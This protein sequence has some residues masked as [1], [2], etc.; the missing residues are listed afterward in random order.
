[1]GVDRLRC[2]TFSGV[3][4]A[5]RVRQNV[6][7]STDWPLGEPLA[8]YSRTINYEAKTSVERFSR[9]PGQPLA[10]AAR[11]LNKALLINV[12]KIGL[13]VETVAP[14]HGPAT[15]WTEAVRRMNRRGEP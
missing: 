7:Q 1:M 4:Y 8:D 9:A 12:E 10:D 14:I 2:V 3:G 5:G 15:P 6:L 11:P 13:E